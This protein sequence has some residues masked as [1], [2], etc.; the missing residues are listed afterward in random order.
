VQLIKLIAFIVAYLLTVMAF[1]SWMTGRKWLS[2][3]IERNENF[4]PP[5]G[6]QVRW[7][8]RHMREDIHMLV[9]TNYALVLLVLF[10]IFYLLWKS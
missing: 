4:E 2:G 5:S 9:L 7:D 6:R 1:G 3:E 8:I 10:L